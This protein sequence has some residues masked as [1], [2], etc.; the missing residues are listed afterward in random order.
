VPAPT[1]RQL[2]FGGGPRFLR[3]AFGATVIFYAGW[4]LHGLLLGVAAATVW[5]LAVYIWERRHAR[6][7]LAARI[8]L[9]IALVQAVAALVSQ[10][11]IGYF[12]PPV[13]VNVVYGTAFLV[14]V[15]IGRPLA[16]VF[17][18]ETYPLPAEVRALPEVHRTFAHISL[19]WGAYLVFRGV[20]R[21]VV[22][23]N[24]SVDVYVA[25]NVATAGPMIVALMTWSFW[26][27]LRRIRHAVT[28]AYERPV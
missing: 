11:P 10:S 5:T 23:L 25:V 21:L 28:V 27:G 24:F 1:L 17:A 9:G 3:D 26:Y 16:A 15:A 4:K 18:R 2:L 7:G 22:L 19:V 12:A 6:P 13:I 14:S 20:F 8:G